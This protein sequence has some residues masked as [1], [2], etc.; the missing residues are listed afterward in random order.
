M[1]STADD[2]FGCLDIE[3]TNFPASPVRKLASY[4]EPRPKPNEV[5]AQA[6]ASPCVLMN[7]AFSADTPGLRRLSP[8]G[9][10]PGFIGHRCQAYLNPAP[11]MR[12]TME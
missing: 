6:V 9:D 12:Q 2:G 7:A 10:R 5:D 11:R 3:N 1:L 4:Q 8:D